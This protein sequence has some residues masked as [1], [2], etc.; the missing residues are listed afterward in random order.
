MKQTHP[1]IITVG[2]P[3]NTQIALQRFLVGNPTIDQVAPE[4]AIGQG[5]I[6]VLCGAPKEGRSIAAFTIA[7]EAAKKA[8]RDGLGP[9]I[10]TTICDT[11]DTTVGKLKRLGCD[12][13]TLEYI[14]VA[15]VSTVAEVTY[16]VAQES[17][18][19]LFA[20]SL[21]DAAKRM[22]SMLVIDDVGLLDYS[23][24]NTQVRE[25]LQ[26]ASHVMADL[27]SGYVG[28]AFTYGTGL[29]ISKVFSTPCTEQPP[30]AVVA[31]VRSSKHG[32]L[33]SILLNYASWG[34][35]VSDGGKTLVP[36]KSR[37]VP[38]KVA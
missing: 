14:R 29:N 24:G 3:P 12:E 38:L 33:P 8:K 25:V 23:P 5:E 2:E 13:D 16:L 11:P 6:T 36:L 7:I 35:S 32:S 17:T 27:A 10:I 9:V 21:A 22:P 4:G 30:M 37:C 19:L 15:R 28:K 31:T 26:R 20:G 18:R 34:L 1:S